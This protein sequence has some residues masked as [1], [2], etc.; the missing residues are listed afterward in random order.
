M[1]SKCFHMAKSSR[2]N[3]WVPNIFLHTSSFPYKIFD[4]NPEKKHLNW[5][6]ECTVLTGSQYFPKLIQG[7]RHGFSPRFTNEA[8]L[9]K[10]HKKE[11]GCTYM[12]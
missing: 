7:S 9:K 11:G 6:C 12:S 10:K 1:E 3:E 2:P 8:G 5:F 4:I